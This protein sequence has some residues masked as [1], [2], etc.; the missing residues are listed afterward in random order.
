MLNQ[1]K[2]YYRGLLDT[3]NSAVCFASASGTRWNLT[4]GWI[5]WTNVS[6]LA[7]LQFT[8]GATATAFFQFGISTS[9]GQISFYFGEHG[10][11]ASDTGTSMQLLTGSAL[12]GSYSAI[13]SGYYTGGG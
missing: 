4:G 6:T 3:S 12:S 9:Q 1:A 5:G 2:A 7:T 13:F 11:Q 10:I 8:E